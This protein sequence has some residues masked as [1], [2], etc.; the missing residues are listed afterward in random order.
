MLSDKVLPG[1]EGEG[2]MNGVVRQ[3]G[4]VL[5]QDDILTT[6]PLTEST[7]L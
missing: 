7:S 4:R 3:T 6:E 2:T 5:A 1:T